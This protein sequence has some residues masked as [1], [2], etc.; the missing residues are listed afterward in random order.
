MKVKLMLIALLGA[1][2]VACNSFR[3]PKNSEKSA[4]PELVQNLIKTS[5]DRK[6]ALGRGQQRLCVNWEGPID[7]KLGT[8]EKA[9]G[10]YWQAKGLELARSPCDLDKEALPIKLTVKLLNNSSQRL[11]DEINSRGFGGS[12]WAQG[13]VVHRMNSFGAE[14]PIRMESTLGNIFGALEDA[15]KGDRVYTLVTDL[16]ST[17]S[18]GQIVHS[19]IVSTM[20]RSWGDLS[21]A[22]IALV[23]SQALAV[24]K[25]LTLK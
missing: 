21:E 13:Q 15:L 14:V 5:F 22:K 25:V 16:E 7:F 1:S 8:L 4:D 6:I 24:Y 11:A 12:V 17:S 19:R 18:L 23:E 3:M 10:S 20:P 2:L 9:A